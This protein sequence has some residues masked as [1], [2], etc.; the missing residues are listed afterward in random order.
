MRSVN[1]FR[2]R[3]A[4]VT[5]RPGASCPL[6][7]PLDVVGTTLIAFPQG[8]TDPQDPTKQLWPAGLAYT[9]AVK[10]EGA[11]FVDR[12]SFVDQDLTAFSF[13][14]DMIPGGSNEWTVNN[15]VIETAAGT[16]RRFAIFGEADWNYVTIEV[17]VAAVGAM[18]GAG[19]GLPVGGVPS[20]GLFAVV[21][22]AGSG[23]R[24]AI[25]R[26]LSGSQF[27]EL[28]ATPLPPG[29]D[30]AAPLL[31]TVVAFDD[32]LR[33]SAGDTTIEAER[34]E[35]REGRACLVAHGVTKIASLKVSG[36]D[37]YRFPFQTSRYRSFDDHI[38][39]FDGVPDVIHPDALGPGTTI[40]SVAAMLAAT[41]VEIAAAMQTG[42]EP[43][44]RQALFERWTQSLGLPLKDEVNAL[45]ISRFVVA[46]K[47]GLFLMESPEP[48]DFT[49]E[50]RVELARRD[51]GAPP[52]VGGTVG[53]KADRIQLRKQRSRE[54]L[55]QILT[56]TD[57]KVKPKP[58]KN[59]LLDV[60]RH[61]TQLDVRL[62][63]SAIADPARPLLIVEAVGKK[64]Q[65]KLIVYS[66]RIPRGASGKVTVRAVKTDEIVIGA[67]HSSLV[68]P[69]LANLA[70]GTFALVTADLREVL[71]TFTPGYVWTPVAVLLIQDAAGTR[72]LMIPANGATHTP[73]VP[74]TYRLKLTL[75]RERWPASDAPD[76]LNRYTRSV[77]LQ[78]TLV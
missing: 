40:T 64:T 22:P 52:P 19:V 1:P 62:D 26:R 21:Q 73:L 68:P 63:L 34:E 48:L 5:G 18:A 30:P 67:G 78:L 70:V 74:G 57:V 35:L 37:I 32:R 54:D 43:A 47:S 36:L 17:M 3:L 15:G 24:L 59:P 33:A 2:A 69:A 55:T 77:T 42:A 16:G 6:K 44:R 31:L 58:P 65:R 61:D 27:D 10:P 75:D 49:E 66:F 41:S 53:S 20:R 25:F 39:S 72:A 8:E 12:S 71:G 28:A 38:Q 46:G 76:E 51:H 4:T 9:A 13:A 56:A 50:I 29:P 14:F 11:G 7:D 23:H 60:T 45:E